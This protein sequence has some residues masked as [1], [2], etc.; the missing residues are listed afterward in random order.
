MPSTHPSL[1]FHVIFST[2]PEFLRESGI[3][4]DERYLW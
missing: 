1:N 3:E 4:Y 2:Y